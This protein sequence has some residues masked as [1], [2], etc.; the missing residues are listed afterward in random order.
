MERQ[1]NFE[2]QTIPEVFK[3]FTIKL[4]KESQ[5]EAYFTKAM[6][7]LRQEIDFKGIF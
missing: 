5:I 7:L 3:N 2:T 4:E 6:D 1:E